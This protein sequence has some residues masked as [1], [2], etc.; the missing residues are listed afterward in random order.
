MIDLDDF[1]LYNDTFG[2]QEGDTL[3]K[4]LGKIFKEHLREVD[5]VC[6]YAGDEFSVILPDTDVDGAVHAAEKIQTAVGD[7]PFK[8]PV[9]LSFGIAGYSKNLTQY[10]LILN[11]DKALYGAKRKGKHCVSVFSEPNNT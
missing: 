2:H 6:R 9:T 3:L 11:A 4:N 10:Q 7:F 5:I 8:K 1:K